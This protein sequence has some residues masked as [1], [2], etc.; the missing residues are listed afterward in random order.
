MIQLGYVDEDVE[1]DAGGL[2]TSGGPTPPGSPHYGDIL[3][4]QHT[5]SGRDANGRPRGAALA[6]AGWSD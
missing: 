4:I 6:G 2:V 3:V 1:L 5:P